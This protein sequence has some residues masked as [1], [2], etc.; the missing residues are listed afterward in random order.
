MRVSN[1]NTLR[2]VWLSLHVAAH[3]EIIEWQQFSAEDIADLL[4]AD[5]IINFTEPPNGN[6]K[7]AGRGGRHVEFGV[8]LGCEVLRQRHLP[9][10]SPRFRLIVIGHRENVFHCLPCI[11]FYATW[12]EAMEALK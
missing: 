6:G 11:E 5:T 2:N 1:L 10:D 8:A 12:P 7:G 4:E 9:L 3:E